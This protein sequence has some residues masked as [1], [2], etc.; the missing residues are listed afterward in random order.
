MP[1]QPAIQARAAPPKKSAGR[2]APG[3]RG[4]LWAG[5]IEMTT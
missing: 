3:A 4:G 1:E 2:R 5:W